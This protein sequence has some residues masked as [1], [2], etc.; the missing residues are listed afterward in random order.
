MDVQEQEMW[1]LFQQIDGDGNKSLSLEEVILFL[2]SIIDDIDEENIE[3]IFRNFDKSGDRSI[4]FEEF[5]V[6]LCCLNQLK[7][8]QGTA[9]WDGI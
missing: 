3:K 4:D 7:S 1:D 5:K 9:S 8:S 6:S 2:K